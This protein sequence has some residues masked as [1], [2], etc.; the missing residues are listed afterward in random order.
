M[1]S[2]PVGPTKLLGE[3]IPS[4]KQNGS[5]SPDV[6]DVT[7]MR[8]SQNDFSNGLQTPELFLDPHTS[9]L[10]NLGAV[11]TA[12]SRRLNSK[13]PFHTPG[14]QSERTSARETSVE[15]EGQA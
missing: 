11:L 13:N 9:S 5:S 4:T 1:N 10:A 6:F 12:P 14:K 7:E 3:M 15:W 8:I 2:K